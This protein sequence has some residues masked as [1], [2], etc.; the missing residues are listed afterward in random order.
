MFRK[1]HG[2]CIIVRKGRESRNILKV[3]AR[4]GEKDLKTA[5]IVERPWEDEI[6]I[7]LP[8]ERKKEVYVSPLPSPCFLASVFK[9]APSMSK[10]AFLG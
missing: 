5:Y 6:A 1:L 8:S 10:M 2:I 7:Q 4:K 3:G 9:T